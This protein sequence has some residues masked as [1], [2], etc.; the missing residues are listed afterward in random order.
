MVDYCWAK[1]NIE[2]DN[3]NTSDSAWQ[4]TSWNHFV[5]GAGNPVNISAGLTTIM[6]LLSYRYET[7]AVGKFG[8]GLDVS[9]M[10]AADFKKVEKRMRAGVDVRFDIKQAVR[11]SDSKRIILAQPLS[12]QSQVST[13]DFTAIVDADKQRDRVFVRVTYDQ[14]PPTNDFFVRV[15]INKPSANAKTPDTDIHY[16]GS[17]AFFGTHTGD[18]HG[19]HQHKTEYLV[20]VTDTLKELKQ[21]GLLRSGEPISVQ[22]VAVPTARSFTK[23]NSQ[24]GLKAIDFI[25]SP[26]TIKAR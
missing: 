18:H 22:L 14:S 5:D 19:K 21:K 12:L 24:F 2:L 15:F 11:I 25:V 4:N 3:D 13:N 17:Y 20:S 8:A 1:W 6:P 23:P 7:S 26:V 10:D 16:A 9:S